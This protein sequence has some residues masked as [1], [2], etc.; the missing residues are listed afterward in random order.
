MLTFGLLLRLKAWTQGSDGRIRLS[1]DDGPPAREFLEDDYDE[2]NEEL[3]AD[4]S[5]GGNSGHERGEGR[6]N[7]D[8]T[9]LT[10]DHGESGAH[11]AVTT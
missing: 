11:T 2:D 1:E 6:A 3:P 8:M 7:D 4:R 5:G 9:T 10:A